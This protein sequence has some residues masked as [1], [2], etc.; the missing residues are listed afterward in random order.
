MST[1]ITK[2]AQIRARIEPDIKA[3]AEGVLTSLGM[4][5]SEAISL[6]LNQIIHHNG[7]PF[8]VRI[9]TDE[10]KA[11]ISQAANGEFTTVSLDELAEQFNLADHAEGKSN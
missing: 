3:G 7:L 5:M 10:L 4:S 1:T 2:S 11:S 8:P 9:P 6:Y